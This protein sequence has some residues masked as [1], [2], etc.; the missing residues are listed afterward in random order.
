MRGRRTTRSTAASLGLLLLGAVLGIVA[1]RI[2]WPGPGSAGGRNTLLRELSDREEEQLAR[3]S[4]T[5]REQLEA[6]QE[7]ALSQFFRL[8]AFR[9]FAE[10][11]LETS[12]IVAV[13]GP[14]VDPWSVIGSGGAALRVPR[15]ALDT[16]GRREW[17][18]LAERLAGWRDGVDERVH[19]SFRQ[20]IAFVAAHPLPERDGLRAVRRTGWSD[21]EVIGPWMSLNR[22]LLERATALVEEY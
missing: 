19:E 11:G 7:Y 16:V 18:L 3:M 22:Q 5:V 9:R 17:R 2:L 8:Q 21:P 13:P 1:T 6:Q 4:R 14:G 20:V 15:V 10:N 12:W